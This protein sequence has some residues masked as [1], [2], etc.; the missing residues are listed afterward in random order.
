MSIMSLFDLGRS[1][2]HANQTALSVTSNN[3]SNVNTEGYSRQDVIMQAA[4]PIEVRGNTLGRGVG[5]LNIRR[6][7]DNFI[8]YQ[9]IGQ[10]SSHGES[11]A[12]ERSLSYIE[13]VFNE[14]QG[15][16][17]SSSM[18][19]YF[20]AWQD[21]ATNPEGTAQ[22]SSLLVKAQAFVNTVKQMESDVEATLKFMNDEIGDVVKQINVLSKNIATINGKIMDQE[23]GGTETANIFRDQREVMMKE[24]AG[25]ADIGWYENDDGSVSIMAGRGS[26]VAGVNSYDLS[27]AINLEGDRDI[28][29]SAG[30][31]I[32]SFFSEGQ[33][34]GYIS[35]RSDI[36]ANPLYDLR[37]M[38]ASIINQTNMIHYAG[39]GLDGT[40]TNDFFD[41]LTVYTR[42]DTD[43]GSVGNVT[44][45]VPIATRANVTLDEYDIVFTA[46]DTFELRDHA[47]GL[48][49]V[50]APGTTTHT[51]PGPTVFT[52]NGIEMTITGTT[53]AG[54][55]FF[56]SP[57]QQVIKNFTVSVTDFN[58]VA[59]SSSATTLPGDNSNAL[60]IVSKYESTITNLSSVSYNDHYAEIVT[61]VGSLAQSASD[62]LEFEDNLLFE[63]NNRRDSVSGV[64]LDEEAANLIRY[65]RAYQASARIITVTD[66][67]LELV[68]NL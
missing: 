63:L 29:N 44:A 61:T 45:T 66:E 27:T 24:L 28:Y 8:Y 47:T 55:A 21:V 58:K 64:S 35:T 57:L 62:S 4:T 20:N 9:I 51:A 30:T 23:A 14:A 67:L 46:A 26:I 19:E 52:Y 2:I 18:E 32:T 11:Y 38:T 49:V 56:V 13:Q 53:A 65:Q 15:F 40:T 41:N 31:K 42:D 43:G 16:G 1:G 54:D 48:A 3:I 37:K 34:G 68:V 5:D 22:R 6:H 50:P 17:L 33:L 60:S 7:F 12:S 10:S 39:Y 59:A 25:L 36:R